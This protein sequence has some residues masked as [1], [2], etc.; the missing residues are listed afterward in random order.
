MAAGAGEVSFAEDSLAEMLSDT[1]VQWE[2]EHRFAA[3]YVGDGRG[4]YD[5][6]RAAGLSDWRMDFAWPEGML[7]IEVEGGGWVGGRHVK[8]RGFEAD[9]RKYDAA[10]RLGWTVYR[11][12]PAMVRDG[13]AIETIRRL[14]DAYRRHGG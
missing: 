12:S 14:V 13:T 8:G 6:L 10:M 5:R 9:L 7:C 3:H 2:R 4:V 11:C 1:G